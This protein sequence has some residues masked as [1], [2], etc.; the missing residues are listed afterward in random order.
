[1]VLVDVVVDV[2]VVVVVTVGKVVD[3]VVTTGISTCEPVSELLV[4]SS[5]FFSQ[6]KKVRL[7]NREINKLDFFDNCISLF[8]HKRGLN[9][10]RTG[11]FSTDGQVDLV[12]HLG[13]DPSNF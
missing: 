9:P 3:V 11:L 5:F 7:N 10:R 12:L 13:P 8:S 1:M 6:A 2:V 4:S